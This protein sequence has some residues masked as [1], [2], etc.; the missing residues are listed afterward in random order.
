[1]GHNS[2]HC[3]PQEIQPQL[4]KW[5]GTESQNGIVQSQWYSKWLNPGPRQVSSLPRSS[6]CLV[7]LPM[8]AWGMPHGSECPR[9]LCSRPSGSC[10]HI[11]PSSQRLDILTGTSRV[12]VIGENYLMTL[13]ISLTWLCNSTPT[14]VLSLILGYLGYLHGHWLYVFPGCVSS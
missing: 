11:S 3:K 12:Y 8:R 10:R 14:T 5:E 13:L 4:A 1:M 7:Y 9:S 6:V 2:P